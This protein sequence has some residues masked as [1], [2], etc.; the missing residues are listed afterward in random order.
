MFMQPKKVAGSSLDREIVLDD[1]LN[2]SNDSLSP[3]PPTT[4]RDLS[5]NNSANYTLSTSLA[6][7]GAASDALVAYEKM[8][9]FGCDLDKVVSKMMFDSIPADDIERFTKQHHYSRK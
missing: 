7:A 8:L 1:F 4:I 3:P 2:D 6:S 9:A 5:V